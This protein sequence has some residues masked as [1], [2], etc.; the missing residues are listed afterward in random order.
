MCIWPLHM[1]ML[2]RKYLPY[3]SIIAAIILVVA[4]CNWLCCH[5]WSYI[6]HRS[7]RTINGGAGGF[8]PHQG[9]STCHIWTLCLHYRACL[10]RPQTHW[11]PIPDNRYPTQGQ[12]WARHMT[13]IR[14]SFIVPYVCSVPN[15]QSAPPPT[16]CF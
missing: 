7:D 9:S 3:S 4:Q 10:T 16:P 12:H 2:E 15:Y 11:L 5:I 14:S 6:S 8:Y 1:T 13:F